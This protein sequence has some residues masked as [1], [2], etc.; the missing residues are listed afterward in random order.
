MF[1]PSFLGVDAVRACADVTTAAGFVKVKET[2]QTE[3]YPE[4]YAAGVAVQVDPPGPTEVP[5]GVPKTGYLSRKWRR[6]W[7][8]TSSPTSR[9]TPR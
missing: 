1:A 8:T 2:Y 9:A 4:V 6:W 5:C 7:S 3:K